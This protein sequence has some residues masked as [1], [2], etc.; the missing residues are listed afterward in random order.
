M[1][2]VR[3]RRSR[4]LRNKMISK[5]LYVEFCGAYAREAK[6][7]AW[8][9]SLEDPFAISPGGLSMGLMQQ[10]GDWQETYPPS[11]DILSGHLYNWAISS[12]RWHPAYQLACYATFCRQ[13]RL[14]E[15]AARLRLYHYGHT[16]ADDPDEYVRK[17]MNEWNELESW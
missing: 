9:E 16:Q 1:G 13:A 17:V 6:A 10:S 7:V 12:G 15:M 3:W 4:L 11:M 8:A 14:L 5:A 2:L